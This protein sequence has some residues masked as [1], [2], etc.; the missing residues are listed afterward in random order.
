MVPSPPT[1]PDVSAPGACGPI[2]LSNDSNPQL[3]RAAGPSDSASIAMAAVIERGARV[4]YAD[5]V[6]LDCDGRLD[7][8][9]Q[10]VEPPVSGRA[11]QLSFLA[12]V[13]TATSHRSILRTPST[14]DG[15]ESAVLALPLKSTGRRDLVVFGSDEGGIA[16]RVFAWADSVYKELTLPA[17]Y[18]LRSEPDWSTQCVSKRMPG[19]GRTGSLVLL[20][21]TISPRSDRGH[22]EDCSMPRDTL[23]VRGDSLVRQ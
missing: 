4:L 8:V 15:P 21:E 20:R 22:G 3:M 19:L 2:R 13:Q 11:R 1:T 12:F 17:E 9:G 10:I 18:M 23:V 5:A 16:P 6:D 14:V 7:L